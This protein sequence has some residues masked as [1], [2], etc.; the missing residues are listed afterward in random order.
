MIQDI[1]G[2]EITIGSYVRY[3]NTGTKGHVVDIKIDGNDT[4]VVL[5]NDLMYRPNLLEV[6]EEKKE[7]KKE[8]LDKDEL[9]KKLIE[10]GKIEVS[11]DIDACGT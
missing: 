3:I 4:W 8:E 10:E 2:N 5:D 6:L 11:N 9:I 7:E 1:N